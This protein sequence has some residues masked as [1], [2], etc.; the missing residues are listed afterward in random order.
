MAGNSFGQLFRITTF[1]ESHG[2]A[3]GVI[4]DGCPPK[5]SVSEADIQKELDRRRPGQSRV[6]TP[7]KEADKAKILSG[8]FNGKTIGTPIALVVENVDVDSSKYEETKNLF[9]PGHADL[10]YSQKFGI[11]D[12]R[13]GGRASARETVARVAAGAIAKKILASHGTRII[14]HTVEI[15]GIRA[16]SFSEKEIEKNIV[17]CADKNA[18]KAMESAIVRAKAEGDSV[19]GIIEV[20]VKK[21]PAGLGEPVFD[22]L[23]AELAK[24]IMSL[25][26][27]KGVEVGV[28]FGAARLKGS[29]CNDAIEMKGGKVSF[30]SNNAGGI[31]GGISTGQDIVLRFV[32]KPP[33]SIAKEQQTVDDKGRNA[34]I[35]VLGRHDPCVA[36][37]AGPIAEAMV[38]I[39][40]ADHLLRQN[41]ISK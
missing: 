16:K 6:T 29:E 13:G 39:V 7:R 21:P 1:G 15:A 4:V 17:R 38:A 11:R 2:T 22:K 10:T 37:R 25:P 8:I 41:A 23:E 5:I 24:A 28:G 32:V 26:A 18:A 40:L 31:L 12:Y 19:G 34:K 36:P 30:R 27:V 9:R 33:S 20:V 35:S 14:S 3:L